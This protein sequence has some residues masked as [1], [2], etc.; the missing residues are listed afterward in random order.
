MEIEKMNSKPKIGL[1]GLTAELYQ[2]KWPALVKD[3]A[4]FS[5]KLS[6]ICAG[7]AEVVH[8]PVICTRRQMKA[9]YTKLKRE[10][11]DGVI[12]I[13]LSYSPSLIIAPTL[14]KNKD[15]PVLIWN[16]QQIAV[17]NKNFSD[18]SSNHGMHGVQDLANVLGRE[19]VLFSLITGH[20]QDK[21]TLLHIKK[22]CRTAHMVRLL[23][24]SKIARIGGRFKYMGDFSIPD[25]QITEILGPAIVNVPL[26]KVAEESLKIRRKEAELLVKSDR[27]EFRVSK[28]L[29]NAT[30]FISTRLE[31][32]LR[33]IIA[34]KSLSGLGI[35][36]MAFRG[37]KGCEVIPFAAIA[38]FMAEGLGYAGEG[39]VL[40]ASAVLIMQEL[41]GGGN[42]VEMFTTDYKK[43]RILM[44]H[45]GES[46]LK[47][48]KEKKTIKLIKKDMTLIKKNLGTAMF[49]FPLK[50]GKVTLFNIAP[51]A[52]GK[53][54]FI[55]SSGQVLDR[56]LLPDIKSP[57]FFFKVSGIEDFLTRYS[58]LGGTHH[59]AM[60]YGDRRQELMCLAEVMKIPVFE[61]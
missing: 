29:D 24:R 31:L 46:N 13:F 38:K 9:G 1:I 28:D 12:L 55:I 18:T 20:H 15:M 42:F 3:L 61:V 58:L 47:M 33:N 30:H 41:C 48:A 32:S 16:T 25:R 23:K 4:I 57:H 26:A 40:C 8:V 51:S 53:F 5:V 43:N 39:D 14:K 44:L 6:K 50:P 21:K 59:L 17:I 2:E 7:F 60:A 27:R 10:G 35:N 11:V 45:M 37:R 56:P 54:R 22:W 52:G 19:K 36:F 34:R 49:L